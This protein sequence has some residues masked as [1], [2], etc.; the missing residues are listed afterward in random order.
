MCSTQCETDANQKSM[1]PCMIYVYFQI[2]RN[3]NSIDALCIQ[4]E[5][6]TIRILIVN[7]NCKPTRITTLTR[8]TC[9]IQ[10]T[11]AKFDVR[12]KK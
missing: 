6:N 4:N 11:A 12:R 3:S 5:G 1:Y 10:L 2:N 7:E 8:F 9:S